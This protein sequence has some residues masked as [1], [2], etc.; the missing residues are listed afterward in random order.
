M[1]MTF[2]L[3]TF[4]ILV[5]L[6][7][8][9]PLLGMSP[10]PE[11]DIE[12]FWRLLF[13]AFHAG[14]TLFG[15]K[16]LVFE[17]YYVDHTN[18]NPGLLNQSNYVLKKLWLVW[19]EN[20]SSYPSHHFVVKRLRFKDENEELLEEFFIIN[21]PACLSIVTYHWKEFKG[22]LPYVKNSREL[23][24]EICN[25]GPQLIKNHRLLG[26]LLGYGDHNTALFQKQQELF[27]QLASLFYLQDRQT[28]QS[29]SYGELV[30]LVYQRKQAINLSGSWQLILN[31]YRRTQAQLSASITSL[32]PYRDLLVHPLMPYRMDPDHPETKEILEKTLATQKILKD[33]YYDPKFLEIVLEKLKE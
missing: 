22:Y 28:V 15:E 3:F 30:S 16:P 25:N 8:G 20:A 5:S 6:L 4:F 21:K 23:V 18:K 32:V 13:K 17:R 29:L 19:E 27:E 7:I 12:N 26:L 14:Y 31:E 1:P 24:E 9:N 2:N 10:N 33:L 11:N